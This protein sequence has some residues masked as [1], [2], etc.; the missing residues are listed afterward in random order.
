M[1]NIYKTKRLSNVSILHIS[2]SFS[3]E[4]TF[5]YMPW[6]NMTVTDNVLVLAHQAYM[7]ACIP[8]SD[9]L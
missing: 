4:M 3:V 1:Q 6:D 9:L 7:H 5:C 8:L 2:T